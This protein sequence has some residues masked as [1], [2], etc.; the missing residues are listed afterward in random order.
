MNWSFDG[1]LRMYVHSDTVFCD[2]FSWRR[3]FSELNRKV[4]KRHDDKWSRMV[5]KKDDVN[6]NEVGNCSVRFHTAS[7]NWWNIG[8]RWTSL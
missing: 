4:P 6:S 3:T 7:M 5:T 1:Q 2:S 8:E